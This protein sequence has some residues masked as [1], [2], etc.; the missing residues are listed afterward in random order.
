MSRLVGNASVGWEAGSAPD[1]PLGH[2]DGV[3]QVAGQGDPV[4]DGVGVPAGAADD[5]GDRRRVTGRSTSTCGSALRGSCD[6]TNRAAGPVRRTEDRRALTGI[7]GPERPGR[8]PALGERS[9]QGVQR[10]RVLLVGAPASS[11]GRVPGS[12]WAVPT[13]SRSAAVTESESRCSTSTPS[14]VAAQRAPTAMSTGRSTS[15]QVRST[16][17][18]GHAGPHG[19]HHGLGVQGVGGAVEPAHERLGARQH[20]RRP[21]LRPAHRRG[22]RGDEVAVSCS[23]GVACTTW[24]ASAGADALQRQPPHGVEPGQVALGVAAVGARRR[25]RS[26]PRS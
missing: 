21:A 11:T 22:G 18:L 9:G 12:S 23:T 1:R 25:A 2:G 20:L 8:D 5:E 6:Q 17:V 4:G 26:G 3:G 7:A 14:P 15:S 19:G 16:P 10:Q 13:T 24:A